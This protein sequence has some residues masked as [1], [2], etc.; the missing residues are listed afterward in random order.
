MGYV[1]GREELALTFLVSTDDPFKLAVAEHLTEA[2]EGFGVAVELKAL[3][4]EDYLAALEGGEY[5]LYLGQVRLRASFDLSALIAPGGS[6]NYG[7][8]QD[9]E[10]QELLSA[11]LAAGESERAEAARRLYHRLA[12]TAP[13]TPLCFKNGSVLSHWGKR[14]DLTPTQSD[15]FYG[16]T[17]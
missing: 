15:I 3:P 5:D 9:R 8:F 11:F 1:T 2:L 10:G 12:A 14:S 16:L 17:H 4:W 7:H 13:F 6:L